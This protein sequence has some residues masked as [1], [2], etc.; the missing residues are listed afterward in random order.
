MITLTLLENSNFISF[1]SFNWCRVTLTDEA[2]EAEAVQVLGAILELRENQAVRAPAVM[3]NIYF[4]T[5]MMNLL[6]HQLDQVIPS[7]L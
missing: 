7:A 6:F 3:S 2:Q 1:S 5:A 4:T